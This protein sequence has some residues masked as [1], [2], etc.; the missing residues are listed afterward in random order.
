MK[1]FMTRIIN[2]VVLGKR[3]RLGLDI[4]FFIFPLR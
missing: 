3:K 1:C 2:P 4:T